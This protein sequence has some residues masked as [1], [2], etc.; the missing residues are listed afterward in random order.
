MT[1]MRAMTMTGTGDPGVLRLAEV[2]R[3]ERLDAEVLVRVVA[4]GVDP[5][6]VQ[7]RAGRRVVRT[8][9]EPIVLGH[10][11]SGVVVEAPYAAH[12]LQP[13]TEVTGIGMPP[14]MTGAYAEYVSAPALGVVRKPASLTHVEAAAVPL[15]ALTAWG[16]VVDVAAAHDGQR[17]LIRG[18]TS[19]AGHLAIQL[20]AH[21]GARVIAVGAPADAAWLRELGAAEVVESADAVAA[22]VSVDLCGE[23]D[24][25]TSARRASGYEAAADGAAL[26]IVMRLLDGGD[27]RVVVDRVLDLADAAQAH[28][29]VESGEARGAVV[30]R[31]A[32]A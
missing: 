5:L 8:T 27:L 2:E 24:E 6:D 30:L 22:D 23:H 16:L 26:A 28:R 12:P 7:L 31:V 3:P 18:G 4:A 1:T 19:A 14:R 29:L 17:M 15:A 10:A 25:V 11:F 9:G 20:A 32:D 21:L 13:G